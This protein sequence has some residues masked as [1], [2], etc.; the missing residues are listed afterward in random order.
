MLLLLFHSLQSQRDPLKHVHRHE[1]GDYLK[2]YVKRSQR[3]EIFS[4][5]HCRW[6]S[7]ELAQSRKDG[8]CGMN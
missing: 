7:K 5:E 4:G 3:E 1:H 8:G 6:E 2:R